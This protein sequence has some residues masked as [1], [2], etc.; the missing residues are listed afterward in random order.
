MPGI[1]LRVNSLRS[2]K[3]KHT[4]DYRNKTA[5]LK[6]RSNHFVTSCVSEVTDGGMFSRCHILLDQVWRRGPR[7]AEIHKAYMQAII[8]ET[9][10]VQ[11]EKIKLREIHWPWLQI[12]ERIS[13]RGKD[14]HFL[15]LPSVRNVA[16]N[17][18]Q[19]TKHID[20]IQGRTSI[21]SYFYE[22]PV[23]T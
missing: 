4:L 19:A 7:R 18:L 16:F 22:C 2:P 5:L 1:Q 6:V 17:K 3:S 23:M 12:F 15:F 8:L 13:W 11:S 9:G 14:Q 10:T 21:Q 20:L